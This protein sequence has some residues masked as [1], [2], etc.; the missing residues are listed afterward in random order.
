MI[1]KKLIILCEPR[2]ASRFLILKILMK[3]GAHIKKT[4]DVNFKFLNNFEIIGILRDPAETIASKVAMSHFFSHD[5]ISGDQVEIE[6]NFD[7]Q[8]FINSYI[9]ITQKIIEKASLIVTYKSI[10]DN[11]EAVV[12][13]IIKKFNIEKNKVIKYD[14]GME[15]KDK[16]DLVDGY[17]VSSKTAPGYK[18]IYTKV[19]EQDL[20]EAYAIYNKAI[21]LKISISK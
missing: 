9:D 18:N 11:S 19:L 4:H 8:N 17:L 2:V 14:P 3:T 12:D 21:G 1:P 20:S 15:I 13:K 16:I 5:L 6:D 10:V 7:W